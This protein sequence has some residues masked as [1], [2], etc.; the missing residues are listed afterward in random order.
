MYKIKLKLEY[1]CFPMWIYDENNILINND[2]VDGLSTNKSIDSLLTSIQ[3]EFDALF[4]DNGTEFY[5]DG[6][7]NNNDKSN[8]VNKVQEV[9]TQ[10]KNEVGKDYIIENLIDINHI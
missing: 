8:F 2:I 3:D 5:F 10:I 6:F 4:V 7:K 9:Y 1:K